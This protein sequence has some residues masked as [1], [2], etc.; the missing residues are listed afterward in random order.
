MFVIKHYKVL[1]RGNA[2][3]IAGVVCYRNLKAADFQCRFEGDDHQIEVPIEAGSRFALMT[4]IRAPD[5]DIITGGNISNI[6][7]IRVT[8]DPLNKRKALTKVVMEGGF[9]SVRQLLIVKNRLIASGRSLNETG[10]G[11]LAILDLNT[12]EL[13][14]EFPTKDL[15]KKIVRYKNNLILYGDPKGNLFL[16]DVMNQK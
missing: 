13:L 5:G 12:I 10:Y 9:G 1:N 16:Y 15:V 6:F 7:K 14:H 3:K 4:A 2:V 11:H 8:E